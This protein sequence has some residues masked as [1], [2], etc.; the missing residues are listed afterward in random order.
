MVSR[1]GQGGSLLVVEV[2]PGVVVVVVLRVLDVGLGV[3]TAFRSSASAR[4]AA[5]ATSRRSGGGARRLTSK[6]LSARTGHGGVEVEDAPQ[7]PTWRAKCRGTV[8]GT[9]GLSRSKESCK[10]LNTQSSNP[11]RASATVLVELD[12]GEHC[13]DEH[14]VLPRFRALLE[15]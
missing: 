10:G 4:A 6:T 5:W 11:Q 3:D 9:V 2:A 14:A 13:R 7:P 8:P 15:R 12:G 1:R